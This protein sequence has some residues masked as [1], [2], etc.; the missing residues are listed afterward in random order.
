MPIK[1]LD[2]SKGKIKY[3]NDNNTTSSVTLLT[4]VKVNGY[5]LYM[6]IC[7]HYVTRKVHFLEF[8]ITFCLINNTIYVPG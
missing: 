7:I 6:Y 5:I 3:N 2:N 1:S 4:A 8:V